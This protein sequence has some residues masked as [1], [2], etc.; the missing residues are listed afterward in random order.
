MDLG[1][2]GANRS[3]RKDP[4]DNSPLLQER[5]RCCRHVLICKCVLKMRAAY[6]GSGSPPGHIEIKV[7]S[8]HNWRALVVLPGIVQSLVKL[9]ATQPIVTFAFQVQVIGNDRFPR[10]VDVAGLVSHGVRRMG[11]WYRYQAW[12]LP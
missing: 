8:E 11:M 5:V 6:R 7:T 12:S 1:W 3:S 2:V 4:I 10:D 9:G